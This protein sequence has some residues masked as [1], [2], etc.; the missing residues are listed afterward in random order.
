M[1][2]VLLNVVIAVLLDEFS[3][4]AE[5]RAR[6]GPVLPPPLRRFRG[7]ETLGSATTHPPFITLSDTSFLCVEVR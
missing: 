4:A 6:A 7:E 5:V 2:L 3:K 1:A